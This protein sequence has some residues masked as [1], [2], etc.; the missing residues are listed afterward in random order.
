MVY[1]ALAYGAIWLLIFGY[2]A[3]LGQQQDRLENQWETFTELTESA[4]QVP[5]LAGQESDS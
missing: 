3:L 1:L 5:A 2:L 4:R